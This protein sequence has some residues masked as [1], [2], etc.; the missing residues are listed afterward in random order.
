[1]TPQQQTEILAIGFALAGAAM[2]VAAIMAPLPAGIAA[3]GLAL[4]GA[5]LTRHRWVRRLALGV[6]VSGTVLGFAAALWI[7][8]TA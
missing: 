4:L 3:I 5:R 8:H 2:G 6:A 1:M 7:S